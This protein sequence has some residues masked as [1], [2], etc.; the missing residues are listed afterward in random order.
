MPQC[1]FPSILEDDLWSFPE[2]TRVIRQELFQ[3]LVLTPTKVSTPYFTESKPPSTA[4]KEK[5]LPIKL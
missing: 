3:L 5:M 2:K 4:R 1:T